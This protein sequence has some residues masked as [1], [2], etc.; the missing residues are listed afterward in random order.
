[1]RN[2]LRSFLIGILLGMMSAAKAQTYIHEPDIMNQF[3]TMETGAG[4]LQPRYYYNLFHKNY[5]KDANARNKIA[6][7]ME[8][9]A[10]MNDEKTPAA[11]I[12]SDYVARAKV[13]AM[14]V[15]SR[16][17]STDVT[18]ALEKKKING[19]LELFQ[20]NINKIVSSGGTSEDYRTWKN[21]YSCIE[22]AIKYTKESYLDMGQRKKEFLAIY[23]DI[24]KRNNQLVRQL[25]CWKGEKYAKEID[26]NNTKIQRLSSNKTIATDALR[27]WQTSFAVGGISTR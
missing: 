20:R 5:Q 18:W 7:R 11:N 17:K 10:L 16:S 12:D 25:V 13:E 21:I 3:T 19:K 6:Y 8:T 26:S 15:V 9:M 24:V 2:I 27:K 1:M 23:K 4:S 22:T 14:N